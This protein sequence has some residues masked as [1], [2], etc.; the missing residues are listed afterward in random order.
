MSVIYFWDDNIITLLPFLHPNSPIYPS[1]F[2]DHFFIFIACIYVYVCI[3]T[4]IH[5]HTFLSIICS[6]LM[7][8]NM[9]FQC[10]SPGTRPPVAVLLPGNDYFSIPSIPQLLFCLCTVEALLTFSPSTL[11]CPLVS[12]FS[13]HLSSHVLRLHGFSFRHL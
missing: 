12:L 8:F 3:H 5:T 11:S 4:R 1:M 6:V 13:S 9:C 10:W 7:L 2:H